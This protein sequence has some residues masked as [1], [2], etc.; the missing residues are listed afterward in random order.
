[1]K[2]CQTKNYVPEINK[3]LK[4]NES[5]NS[6]TGKT[7]QNPQKNSSQRNLSHHSSHNQSI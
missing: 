7:T 3:N 1:M 6:L 2:I 5:K 4:N